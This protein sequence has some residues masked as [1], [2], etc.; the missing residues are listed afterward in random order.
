MALGDQAF[1]CLDQWLGGTLRP[2]GKRKGW[3]AV[4]RQGKLQDPVSA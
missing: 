3:E 1:G 2:G 4:G